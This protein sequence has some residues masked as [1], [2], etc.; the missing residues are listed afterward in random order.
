MNGKTFL[1][2]FEEI[3]EKY[4][5]ESAD[6]DGSYFED[7][8]EGIAVRAGDPRKIFWRTF[9]ASV[10]CTA[11][12]VVGAVFLMRNVLRNGFILEPA[13]SVDSSVQGGEISSGESTSL[14]ESS[15]SSV[16]TD[17]PTFLV[18]P[19]GKAILKSEITYLTNTKKTV[20]TL[21]END[22]GAEIYCEGFAYY[23][24][25]CGVGYDSYKNPELF[26]GSDFLGEVPENTNAWKRVYVGDEICG[27]KVKSATAH[28][29]VAGNDFLSVPERHFHDDDMG[30]ELEGTV[31]AEGFLEINSRSIHE[32]LSELMWFYPSA[33]DLPLTPTNEIVDT[34]RGFETRFKVRGLHN[35]FEDELFCAGEFEKITLGLFWDT[36]CDMDGLGIG[37]VAYARVTFG[38]IRCFGDQAVGR[39]EKV[40]R[41]SEILA[42]VEDDEGAFRPEDYL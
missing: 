17:E 3:D 28:F 25:P 4:I 23:K 2:I 35:N 37:D 1:K 29:T 18:G 31:E 14:D 6:D 32:E 8:G 15:V 7:A 13:S 42:H 38:D 39:I 5:E 20:D 12:V 41:L 27:L 34:E 33:V 16:P 30:I 11:A 22:I 40:E 10:A 9:I 36:D 26:N 24:L 19:D 21:T